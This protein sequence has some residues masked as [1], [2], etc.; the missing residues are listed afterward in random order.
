MW[1]RKAQTGENRTFIRALSLEQAAGE[2]E[3][4][5]SGYN[6][7]SIR[8]PVADQRRMALYKKIDSLCPRE[9]KLILLL[10]DTEL[11][12]QGDK[13][14][15]DNQLIEHVISF[16]K[17]NLSNGLPWIVHCTNGISRSVAIAIILNHQVNPNN[18]LDV[19]HPFGNESTGTPSQVPNS[20]ILDNAMRGKHIPEDARD[21]IFEKYRK[22]LA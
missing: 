9:Q 21:E 3:R 17:E 15:A 19:F 1:Y 11:P 16:F 4:N 8:D 6:V 22:G 7:I 12:Q 5:P 18:Y 10:T 14:V 2:I 13:Y 20:Y